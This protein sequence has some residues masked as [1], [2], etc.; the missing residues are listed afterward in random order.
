MTSSSSI[1]RFFDDRGA[2]RV[3]VET[4]QERDGYHGGF[5]FVQE[6][7]EDRRE[8]PDALRGRTRED[9]VAKAY[10]LPEN[11]IRQIFR[12]LA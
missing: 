6:Q 4:W 3:Q 5:V 7:P 1:R 10:E 9:V 2:W 12:S 11:R 8:G